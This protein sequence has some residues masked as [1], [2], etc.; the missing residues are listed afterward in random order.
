MRFLRTEIEIFISVI[1]FCLFGVHGKG[2]THVAVTVFP[3]GSRGLISRP[4]AQLWTFPT[5]PFGQ[6]TGLRERFKKKEKKHGQRGSTYLSSQHLES[7]GLGVQGH[8]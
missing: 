8:P 7:G 3:C 6:L 2:C 1:T 5:E 4:Q